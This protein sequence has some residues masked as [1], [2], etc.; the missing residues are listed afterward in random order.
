MRYVLLQFSDISGDRDAC[1][2]KM[3]GS[4]LFEGINV[5]RTAVEDLGL[6]I[7]HVF[8]ESLELPLDLKGQFASVA[9]NNDV[10][11]SVDGSQLVQ[12]GQH[13]NGGL[14]HARLGLTDNIHTENG[15]GNAFMLNCWNKKTS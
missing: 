10:S 9:K 4:W 6:D 8:G 5:L 13:K 11:F 2:D 12:C 1:S 15:V 14:A 7:L 3:L